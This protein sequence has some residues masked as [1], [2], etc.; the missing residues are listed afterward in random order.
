M[1][2]FRL[3]RSRKADTFVTLAPMRFRDVRLFTSRKA[4]TSATL[5]LLMKIENGSR[6][7]RRIGMLSAGMGSSRFKDK[8]PW[9]SRTVQPCVTSTALGFWLVI[10]GIK[11]AAI[12]MTAVADQ[13][14][15]GRQRRQR[16]T[17]P[18]ARI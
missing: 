10:N 13:G 12:P 2:C 3:F 17:V 8:A 6:R 9:Y 18:R 14:S 1:R 4:N 5:A 15:Q 7:L 16:E 11:I